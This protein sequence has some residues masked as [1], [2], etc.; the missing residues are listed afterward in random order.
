MFSK[1]IL[2]N[3]SRPG[4][5]INHEW[6][7]YYRNPGE[8]KLKFCLAYPDLYEVGMSNLGFRIIYDLL[9]QEP[10][11]LCE[12]VFLPW[13]DMESFLRKNKIP[14]AS[15]ESKIP[16]KDFD[17]LGISLHSELNYTG[18]LNLLYLGNI[19]LLSAER[20]ADS[21]LI[22][23]GG[24]ACFNPEPLADFIDLFVI[25]EGE[26]VLLEIVNLCKNRRGEIKDK[27]GKR[28]LLLELAHLE[29]VYVPSLY[30]TEYFPNGKISRFYPLFPGLAPRIKKRIVSDLNNA[31]YPHRTV[32]PYIEIIHDRIGIE[33]MR[34]CPHRCRFC[35]ARNIYYPRRERSVEKIK[36]LAWQNFLSSGY[37]EIALL[38][39][40]SL[41]YSEIEKLFFT[42][43]QV[44]KPLGVGLSLPSLRIKRTVKNLL[45]AYQGM[46]R[47]GLTFAPEAGSER[48]RKI[49]NK[50]I[51][52]KIFYEIV[53]EILNSGWQGLKLYFML[54]LP[55]EN[56]K[57]LAET[58]EMVYRILA[59]KKKGRARI[60]LSFNTF[61]PKPHTSFQW[62]SLIEE[63]LWKEKRAYLEE[64]LKHKLIRYNF[65]NYQEDWLETLLSRGDRKLGKVILKAWEK[66][67]RFEAWREQFNFKI[68]QEAIS[69]TGIEPALYI[70][71]KRD[72][73]EIFPWDFIETGVGK[74]ELVRDYQVFEKYLRIDNKEVFC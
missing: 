38:S 71:E 56:E 64:K 73:N 7:A 54:G 17:L 24:S 31:P 1:E 6:N 40:S 19:P 60:H 66:G 39:L 53:E 74:E 10:D 34:G 33:I 8:V 63:K 48:M 67:A 11:L 65:S 27:E 69:E 59:M 5:Y 49:I 47:S 35:Q 3:V 41:D 23:A 18:V 62:L 37:E 32:V 50:K 52:L 51:D 26:E 21:P 4:R 14:L 25:G 9:N 28:E 22:V 44:F 72:L 13:I 15:L 2:L 68:W 58:V 42:L 45:K 57:D 43:S 70:Y 36:E 12:R 61:I 55:G 29:G 46:R 20:K 16:L 30:K